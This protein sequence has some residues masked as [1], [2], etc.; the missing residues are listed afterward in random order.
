MCLMRVGDYKWGTG[1]GAFQGKRDRPRFQQWQLL[2]FEL[3]KPSRPS[4]SEELVRPRAVRT[5]VLRDWG[6]P[7][8]GIWVS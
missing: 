2:A 4:T 5:F 3:R 6:S 1:E 7:W 8:L